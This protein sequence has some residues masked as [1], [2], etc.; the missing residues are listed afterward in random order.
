MLGDDLSRVN[1]PGIV[2][3]IACHQQPD[4][5]FCSVLGIKEKDLRFLY[6][7]LSSSALLKDWSGVDKERAFNYI[8]S[9]QN[10]DGAFGLAPTLESHGGATYC[11]VASLQLLG[12]LDELPNKGRLINWL[13]TRQVNG[14][15]G[16]VNKVPDSCYSFWV[17]AALRMLGVVDLLE[18]KELRMFILECQGDKGGF[19][20]YPFSRQPDPVH[21]LLSLFGLSLIGGSSAVR[22]IDEAMSQPKLN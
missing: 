21:T 19:K 5:S 11:A 22:D 20:K 4:G 10:Y 1:K 12:R 16:R 7:A 18:A 8:L 3:L 14:V 15:N 13:T 9:C 2:R 6:A 17:G